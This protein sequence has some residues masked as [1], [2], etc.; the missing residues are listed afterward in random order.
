MT[1][2]FRSDL[3]HMPIL[4]SLSLDPLEIHR[5]TACTELYL[6][7]SEYVCMLCKVCL[8]YM[9]KHFFTNSGMHILMHVY[10]WVVYFR[11]EFICMYICSTT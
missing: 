3:G 7:D 2:G 8:T 10:K 6:K 4:F 1:H 9:Q 11:L 5:G